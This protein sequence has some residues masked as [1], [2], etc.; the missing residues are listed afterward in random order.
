MLQTFFFQ[1]IINKSIF[2]VV[3]ISIIGQFW[4]RAASLCGGAVGGGSA[5]VVRA[6]RPGSWAARGPPVGGWRN[7]S[8]P[9][10]ARRCCA[11]TA[12]AALCRRRLWV[13]SSARRFGVCAVADRGYPSPAGGGGAGSPSCAPPSRPV[14]FHSA[15]PGPQCFDQG[16]EGPDSVGGAAGVAGDAAVG[17]CRQGGRWLLACRCAAAGPTVGMLQTICGREIRDGGPSRV[18][19]VGVNAAPSH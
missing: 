7:Y 1:K 2:W 15:P 11:A 8:R 9:G 4:T 16:P 18:R 5:A 6:A 19:F 17:C 12:A 13:R 3:E 10:L 14:A